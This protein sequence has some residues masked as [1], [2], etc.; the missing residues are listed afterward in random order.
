MPSALTFIRFENSD[1]LLQNGG[2][3]LGPSF[4]NSSKD[5]VLLDSEP[6]LI[7]SALPQWTVM[8]TVKYINAKDFFVP[9]GKAAIELVSVG[10][11]VQTVKQ[12]TKGSNYKL[13]F[14]VGDANDSC[15]GDFTVG[16]VAGSLVQNFTVQS[17]GTGSG[18][19]HSVTFQGSGESTSEISFQ[20]YTTRQREDGGLCGPVI[21]AVVL[22]SS[23]GH[24]SPVSCGF[25]TVLLFLIVRMIIKE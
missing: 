5:G 10:S 18:K 16:V 4:P 9:Q 6:S 22:L 3:E 2:F 23:G 1:N 12:L 14:M 15:P 8:G 19:N 17:N 7:E 25:F 11:G 13:E 20:S 21:D 24:K